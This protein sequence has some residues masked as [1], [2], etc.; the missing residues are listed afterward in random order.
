IVAALLAADPGLA[1]ADLA[2]ALG[3]EYQ[4]LEQLRYDETDDG[5]LLSVE[6]AFELS[7]RALAPD[8]ARVV[9]LLPLAPGPDASTMAVAALATLPSPKARAAL[10]GLARAHLIEE[11]PIGAGRWQMHDLVHLYARRLSELDSYALDSDQGLERVL[12]YYLSMA[13]AA[14]HH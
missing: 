3:S 11:I 7:Y 6:A 14:S 1:T 8:S 9:R 12:S 5:A 10:A 4:R 2:A 13:N